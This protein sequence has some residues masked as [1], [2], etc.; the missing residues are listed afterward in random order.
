MTQDSDLTTGVEELRAP[1]R[2][3]LKD[4]FAAKAIKDDSEID[5]SIRY[6]PNLQ[7]RKSNFTTVVVELSEGPFPEILEMRH[8]AITDFD[9]PIEVYAACPA[10]ATR[11]TAGE[12]EI[13][14]LTKQGFGL[15]VVDETGA[16]EVR[17][18]CSALKL[19]VSRSEF[20]AA[21]GSPPKSVKDRLQEAYRAY[22]TSPAGGLDQVCDLLE[23]LVARAHAD[24]L[25][26]GW[27]AQNQA[28]DKTATQ[29][30][31][32][33]ALNQLG[34]ARAALCIRRQ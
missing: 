6:T 31:H 11:T 14:R 4:E 25:K 32:M 28:T 2:K 19:R 3:L 29:I 22:Q 26:K 30:D 18:A 33:V 27:L 16:A 24:C 1:V 17:H 9:A 15:I 8:T 10:E 23:A 13:A 5:A 7:F 20:D 21:V 34:P 12:K